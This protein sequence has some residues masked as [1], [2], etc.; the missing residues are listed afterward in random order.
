VKALHAHEDEVGAN[1]PAVP[2]AI[3]HDEPDVDALRFLLD[4]NVSAWVVR[5][6]QRAGERPVQLPS[7]LWSADARAVLAEAQRQRRILIT[8]EPFIV[9][10]RSRCEARPG[11]VVLPRHRAGRLDWP[12]IAAIVAEVARRSIEQSVFCIRPNGTFTVWSPSA[13]TSG[14]DAAHGRIAGDGIVELSYEDFGY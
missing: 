3:R 2:N 7:D 13:Y 8:H 9:A 4:N 10:R 14:M 11:I 12:I 5:A 6:M 1:V